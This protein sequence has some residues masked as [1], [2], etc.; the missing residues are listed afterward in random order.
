MDLLHIMNRINK[1]FLYAYFLM[2]IV[3]FALPFFS[4]EGYSI[5]KNTTSQL[6]A[7]KTPNAW[8]MNAV[9]VLLGVSSIFAGWDP[10]KGYWSHRILLMIFGVSLILTAIFHHAPLD[11]VSYDE[12]QDNL[13]SVFASITGF[14]FTL[15]AFSIAFTTPLKKDK[16]LAVCIGIF[17]TL[18]SFFM[19]SLPYFAG[20][21]QRLIF[22]ISFTW[23]IYIFKKNPH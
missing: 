7:Q 17:A 22:I 1:I 13:H 5:L 11:Q 2:L 20:I 23:L 15:L 9:F 16:I 6:G 19:F 21:W 10:L 3:I 18:L 4:V 12:S 14:S 8:V